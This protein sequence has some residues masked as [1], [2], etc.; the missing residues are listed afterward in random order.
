M[1]GRAMVEE[2]S[3]SI[4]KEI[5]RYYVSELTKKYQP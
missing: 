3:I 1:Y 4:E 2:E 5:M